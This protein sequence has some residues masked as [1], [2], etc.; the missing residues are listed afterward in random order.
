[1]TPLHAAVANGHAAVCSSL[2]SASASIDVGTYFGVGETVL[3][4]LTDRN[5]AP[6]VV[7]AVLASSAGVTIPST[8]TAAIN[9][10]NG[11]N[12]SA[13]AIVASDGDYEVCE[14]LLH[15]KADP[16]G[17]DSNRH[18]QLVASDPNTAPVWSTPLQI[19]AHYSEFRVC[20][21]LLESMASP[22]TNALCA[23]GSALRRAFDS[24]AKD[25]NHRVATVHVLRARMN[26]GARAFEMQAQCARAQHIEGHWTNHKLFDMNL[27]REITQYITYGP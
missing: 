4:V 11:G 5:R 23:G 26:R 1:M 25:W 13:L 14:K 22:F 18:A 7:D 15:A 8:G 12:D 20:S 6:D 9:A 16:E 3:H 19:A 2:L 27:V 24:Q 21:L 10:W 17:F